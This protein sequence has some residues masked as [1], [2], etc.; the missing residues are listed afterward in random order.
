MLKGSVGPGF[1]ISTK[2]AAGKKLITTKASTYDLTI[3]DK[4]AFLTSI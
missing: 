2:N 3:Q 4:S 1:V